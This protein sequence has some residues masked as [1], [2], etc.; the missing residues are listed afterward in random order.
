MSASLSLA[1]A[2]GTRPLTRH[3]QSLATAVLTGYHR[4]F[5]LALRV[6]E[7]AAVSSGPKLR[8]YGGRDGAD[9]TPTWPQGVEVVAGAI[10]PDVNSV[11]EHRKAA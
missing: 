6:L 5:L 11:R 2:I 7:P 9:P 3:V 10:R 1:R 4:A 8:R